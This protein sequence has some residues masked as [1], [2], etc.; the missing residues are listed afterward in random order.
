[1]VDW[2]DQPS[3]NFND[4]SPT[5]SLR[6]I[7]IHYTGM[8]SGREALSRLCDQ[9]AK[10]SSHYFIEED[11]TIYRLVSEE[12]RAWHAGKS[13]WKGETDLNSAS[14]GIELVNPGHQFGYR[15]FSVYQINSLKELCGDIIR[16]HGFSSKLSLL[17][18]SDIA[19]GRKEDPGELFPWQDMFLA[20][21]GLWPELKSGD[22]FSATDGDIQKLLRRIGYSCPDHGEYDQLTR[23]AL[24][25]FQ[26]RFHQ[27]NLTGTPELETV[28]RLRAVCRTF[29]EEC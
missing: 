3:P 5:V 10:V 13:Y 25:A 11:G 26:R 6:Y 7:V 9:S 20:G 12:K 24:L 21:F 1:M 29:D 16:R 14:L 27:E 15:P 8:K 4:R 2:I 23:E 19:P 28:A 22:Y 17:A 18:H